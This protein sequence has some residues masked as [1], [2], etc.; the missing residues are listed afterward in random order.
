MLSK[1]FMSFI[2]MFTIQEFLAIVIAYIYHCLLKI[3]YS[4][5]FTVDNFMEYY[6]FTNEGK[7]RLNRICRL[8]DGGNTDKSLMGALLDGFD[9]GAVYNIY[10]PNSLN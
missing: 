8:I 5:S 9:M 4:E 3:K 6:N 2:S 1:D 7:N 10:E